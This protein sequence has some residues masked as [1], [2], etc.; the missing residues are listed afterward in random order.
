MAIDKMDVDKPKDKTPKNDKKDK[1]EDPDAELSDEDLE[2]KKNLDLMVER[3]GDSDPG[4]HGLQSHTR[5][6]SQSLRPR[7]YGYPI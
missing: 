5:N 7:I 4:T 6:M 1:K 2:L 3:V